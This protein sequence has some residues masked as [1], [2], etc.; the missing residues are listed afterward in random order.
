MWIA[1]R[2]QDEI[3]AELTC[4]QNTQGLEESQG[5]SVWTPLL[6]LLLAFSKLLVL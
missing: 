5:N 2:I 4:P 3:R 6:G 1:E